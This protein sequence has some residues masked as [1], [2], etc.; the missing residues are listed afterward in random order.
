M[1]LFYALVMLT[2]FL[3]MVNGKQEE[4]NDLVKRREETRAATPFYFEQLLA[5]YLNLFHKQITNKFNEST[6]RESIRLFAQ[7]NSHAAK[8]Y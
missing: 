2:A 8:S 4:D 5:Y 1:K 3:L 6:R 7:F